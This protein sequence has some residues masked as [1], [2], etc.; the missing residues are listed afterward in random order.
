M[1][2]KQLPSQSLFTDMV[3]ELPSYITWATDS[4]FFSVGSP[5]R[6]GVGITEGLLPLLELI[7][8]GIVFLGSNGTHTS[9]HS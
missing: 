1:G 6:L 3:C 7:E 5:D 2:D 4:C 9:C 8:P